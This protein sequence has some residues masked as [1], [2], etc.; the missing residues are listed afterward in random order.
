MHIFHANVGIY[1]PQNAIYL[2]PKIFYDPPTYDKPKF[3][4]QIK[5]LYLKPKKRSSKSNKFHGLKYT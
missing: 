4:T 3:A 5:L 2:L 1:C